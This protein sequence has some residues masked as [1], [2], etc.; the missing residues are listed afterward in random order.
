MPEQDMFWG[1]LIPVLGVRT[2]DYLSDLESYAI[3]LVLFYLQIWIQK[4]RKTNV[5]LGN[6]FEVV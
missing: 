6:D 1:Y 3:A 2:I 5:E 4:E